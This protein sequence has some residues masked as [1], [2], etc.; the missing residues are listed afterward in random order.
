MALAW[1]LG[2][3][4]PYPMTFTLEYGAP[5]PPARAELK[6]V[7]IDPHPCAEALGEP[8]QII[9][10]ATPIQVAATAQELQQQASSDV[11]MPDGSTSASRDRFPRL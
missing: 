9:V 8:E 2:I 6:W 3:R 7:A 10:V 1:R 11:G 4:V 5:Q